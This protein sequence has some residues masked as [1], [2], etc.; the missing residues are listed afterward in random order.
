MSLEVLKRGAR[1]ARDSH[2]ATQQVVPEITR[3]EQVVLEKE[4]TS[5]FGQQT[6]E[7]KVTILTVACAAFVQSVHPELRQG[8]Q[9]GS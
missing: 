9:S 1:I 6:K 2:N 4:K 5:G 7:L 8:R 3:S